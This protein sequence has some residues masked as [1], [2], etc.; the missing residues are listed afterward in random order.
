[1][2]VLKIILLFDDFRCDY[3]LGMSGQFKRCNKHVCDSVY[4]FY[5]NVFEKVTN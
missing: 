4:T 2:G 3:D 5:H 1:M